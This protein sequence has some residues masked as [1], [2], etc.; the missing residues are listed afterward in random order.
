MRSSFKRKI[1]PMHHLSMFDSC[2]VL[3]SSLKVVAFP[4][5]VRDS[6]NSP[7]DIIWWGGSPRRG[8]LAYFPP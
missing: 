7:I 8:L 1:V 3:R 5:T 6:F 4:R 2:S